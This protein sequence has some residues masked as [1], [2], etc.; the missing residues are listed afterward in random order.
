MPRKALVLFGGI[1]LH[2]PR[3]SAEMVQGMLSG[4]GFE[5]VLSDDPEILGRID[6][7]AI[8]IVIPVVTGGI[9]SREAAGVFADATEAGLGVAG[10]HAGLAT[11]F[12]AATRFKCVA[13]CTFVGHPGDI[14]DY[15]VNFI[16]D[17]PIVAGLEDFTHHSEQYYLQYDPAWEILATTTF[18]GGHADWAQNM[19]MPVVTKRRFGSGRVFYS[20]LGHIPDEF[21]R[22][23]QLGEILRRGILWAARQ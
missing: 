8:D 21:D 10:Y 4:L 11:T 22:Q 18:S 1:E 13:G 14:I 3:R 12:P 9:L 23:P 6:L 19:I 17:D 2:Q 16:S 7:A 5:T 15:P 20:S